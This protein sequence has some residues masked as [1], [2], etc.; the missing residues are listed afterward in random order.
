M[1]SFNAYAQRAREFASKAAETIT[2]PRGQMMILYKFVI[3]AALFVLLAPGML[4]NL[5]TN[6]KDTC[7]KQVP[8]PA[9]ATEKCDF[10]NGT[11]LGGDPDLDV[12]CEKQ[13][14][15]HTLF[16]SGYTGMWAVYLHAVV[17]V[18]LLAGV[19]MAISKRGLV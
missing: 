18:L 10:S 8:L 2:E 1:N 14:K 13:K 11:Y 15:C 5:P 3:P 12:I 6:S 4:L 7:A 19:N 17:F 9:N 16:A